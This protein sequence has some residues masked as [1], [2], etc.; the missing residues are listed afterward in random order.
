MWSLVT[1]LASCSEKTMW[2]SEQAPLVANVSNKDITPSL[3]LCSPGL[4]PNEEDGDSCG[5][6]KGTVRELPTHQMEAQWSS[7]FL[8]HSKSFSTFV[9]SS[10]QW[11]DYCKEPYTR[12]LIH[13]PALIPLLTHLTNILLNSVQNYRWPSHSHSTSPASARM[14]SRASHSTRLISASL[15]CFMCEQTGCPVPLRV[16]LPMWGD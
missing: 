2:N 6:Q 12:V 3:C 14:D 7:L 1:L 5:Y 4:A 11:G 9:R 8:W 13:T 15:N 10:P 16:P